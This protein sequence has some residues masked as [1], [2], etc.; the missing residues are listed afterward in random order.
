MVEVLEF[1]TNLD[2]FKNYLNNLN[3]NGGGIKIF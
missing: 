3:F 2:K 1:E